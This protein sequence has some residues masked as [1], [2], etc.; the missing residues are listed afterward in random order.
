[1]AKI[2]A[3]KGADNQFGGFSPFGNVTALSYAYATNATGVVIGS[4][5]T[6]PVAIGDIIY[7]GTAPQGFVFHNI[8]GTIAKVG[9]E[10]V[11]GA[12]STELPQNVD[13]K[14]ALLV[15]LPK[16]AHIYVTAGAAA[17]SAAKYRFALVGELKG[18]K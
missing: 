10:Y 18:P 5:A 4:N 14:T 7:V 2:K 6:A 1:M 13:I 3:Y 17:S 9:F 12:D 11:D 15:P 8:Y 16:D